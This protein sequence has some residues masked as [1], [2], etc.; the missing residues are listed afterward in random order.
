MG[1]KHHAVHKDICW[2]YKPLEDKPLTMYGSK[3]Q[4][5]ECKNFRASKEALDSGIAEDKLC[6]DC[7]NRTDRLGRLVSFQKILKSK[8]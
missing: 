8:S 2:S 6:I 5:Y 1:T 4:L 7:I 3:G